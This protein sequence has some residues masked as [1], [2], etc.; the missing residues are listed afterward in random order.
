MP[1]IATNWET[2]EVSFYKFVC[3][4][5]DI[6]YS[7]VGHTT[8]F[9]HR[10]AG[11]KSKYNNPTL[12]DCN[13]PLYVFIKE[14]G[15]WDNWSM[16]QIHSQICKDV[17][18][19]KQIEQ[20]LIEQQ[21]FKL[22]NVRAYSGVNLSHTHPEYTSK[23]YEIHCDKIK[24]RVSKYREEN[25]DVIKAKKKE[26]YEANC[27]TINA[28]ARENRK[29]NHDE[30]IKKEAEYR[31][32]NRDILNAKARERRALKKATQIKQEDEKT[33]NLIV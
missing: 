27:D 19:A 16:V 12:R 28:K 30:I 15:G 21:Q 1:K 32:E 4:N 25:R 20:E 18:H 5:P 8:S 31:K 2:T 10:K 6:L 22:N 11:H 23:Y 9:R 7:Y 26:I 3:K 14:H 17:L 29:K 33:V 24:Q 13:I